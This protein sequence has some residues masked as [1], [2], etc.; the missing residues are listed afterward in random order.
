VVRLFLAVWLAVLAVQSTDLVA[1]L[2]P[3]DCVEGTRDSADD[4]CAGNCARC[5]CCARFPVF[6]AQVLASAVT[7]APVAT[8]PIPPTDSSSSPVARGVL[9]V[10]KT[11]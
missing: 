10:P 7:E 6:V 1:T 2:V 8:D 3:D 9:H 4:P 5:V 11:L